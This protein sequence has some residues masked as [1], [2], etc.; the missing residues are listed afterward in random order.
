MNIITV[1]AIYSTA[2]VGP[3]D[4]IGFTNVT[5]L[6]RTMSS[7]GLLLQP[8]RP[9]MAADGYILNLAFPSEN[10][11]ITRLVW[12]TYS[13]VSGAIYGSVLAIDTYS[14]M[15]VTPSDVDLEMLQP[16]VA[17]LDQRPDDT[18]QLFDDS[19]PIT[20]MEPNMGSSS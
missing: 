5:L 18:I 4:S 10:I 1:I 14:V 8:S 11:G 6:N 3:S 20:L 15:K 9:M 7:D 13:N 16:S 2:P 12:S 17:Y 19:H